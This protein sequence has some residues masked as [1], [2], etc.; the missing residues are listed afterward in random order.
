M[1][2]QA[3]INGFMRK[4]A[5][6][7]IDGRRLLGV[8]MQKRAQQTQPTIDPRLLSHV[9]AKPQKT[10]G[11]K[12]HAV[13]KYV[14]THLPQDI[15]KPITGSDVANAVT[16]FTDY[17]AGD[18]PAMPA[19]GDFLLQ[20]FINSVPDPGPGVRNPTPYEL[21]EL[22]LAALARG[23]KP[24]TST[25]IGTWLSSLYDTPNGINYD[26]IARDAAPSMFAANP[27]LQN[28]AIRRAWKDATTEVPIRATSPAR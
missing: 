27:E 22:G 23:D 19:F 20:K 9:K 13:A 1:I 15:H 21:G 17:H 6:H 4:C 8:V 26:V 24:E 28:E 3:Y 14:N 7:G 12:A 2:K 5:E 25:A 10:Q 11:S 16:N 18:F